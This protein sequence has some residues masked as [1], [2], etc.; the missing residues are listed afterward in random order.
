MAIGS[1]CKI[2]LADGELPPG[3]LVVS[4]SNHYAVVAGRDLRRTGR[5]PM[6]R[7][8]IRTKPPTARAAASAD[9]RALVRCTNRVQAAA[10]LN[11]PG[12]WQS[13][14]RPRG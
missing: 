5:Q 6:S 13:P 4:V 2:H 12:P 14:C 8:L 11:P 9:R 3:R 10:G 7:M 1:G